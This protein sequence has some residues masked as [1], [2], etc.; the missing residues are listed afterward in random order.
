MT[1][2]PRL[3][4]SSSNARGPA[5]DGR[6][7][8]LIGT[9]RARLGPRWQAM[10]PRERSGIVLAGVAVAILLVWSI[11][12]QP[13]LDTLSSLP[14]KQAEL[15]RQWQQMSTLATEARELRGLAPLAPAQAEAA[16]KSATEQ[17]GAAARLSMQGDR[18]VVTVTGVEPAALMAWLGEVRS[19]ARARV[20]EAQLRRA[21][22]VSLPTPAATRG[23]VVAPPSAT[24][25]SGNIVLAMARPG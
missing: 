3:Q 5:A 13:A 12:V 20:V 9:L 11:A 10:A 4:R 6:V 21:A 22:P 25:L 24:G 2:L 17:L 8:R 14:P 18:A 7:T 23:A 15:D 1:L 16:L 19:A